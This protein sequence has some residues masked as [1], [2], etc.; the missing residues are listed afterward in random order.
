ML[1]LLFDETRWF[2]KDEGSSCGEARCRWGGGSWVPEPEGLVAHPFFFPIFSPI[3]FAFGCRWQFKFVLYPLT[4]D[5]RIIMI[6]LLAVMAISLPPCERGIDS[7]PP[8]ESGMFVLS[9]F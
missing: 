1:D 8:C 5:A 9:F 3:F 7:L 6:F 2:S 4:A